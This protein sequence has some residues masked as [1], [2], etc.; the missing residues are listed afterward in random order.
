MILILGTKELTGDMLLKLAKKISKKIDI[1][2]L[3]R[4]GLKLDLSVVEA[5][6]VNN[7][8]DV[9]MAM[10]EVLKSF[11]VSQPDAKIAYDNLCKALTAVNMDSLIQEVLQ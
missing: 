3:G 5:A 8:D 11:R 9:N 2:T 4:T 1:L 6:I 7:N 10:Y